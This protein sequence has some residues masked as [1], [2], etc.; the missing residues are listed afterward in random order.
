MKRLFEISS[1]EKQ[2]ILEMHESATKRN[3]LSEQIAVVQDSPPWKA[4]YPPKNIL[5]T[6]TPSGAIDFNN[7]IPKMKTNSQG[8]SG[9]YYWFYTTDEKGG[10]DVLP[11]LGLYK[12]RGDI[13]DL[14]LNFA[15]KYNPTAKQWSIQTQSVP[16]ANGVRFSNEFILNN[17]IFKNLE[18][19]SGGAVDGYRSG[20][21]SNKPIPIDKTSYELYV[22][23]FVNKN[24]A[25]G[26]SKAFKANLAP[27]DEFNQS[28]IDAIKKSGLYTALNTTTAPSTPPAPAR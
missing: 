15:L 24:P 6:I 8:I 25:S 13:G 17:V 18:G 27:N 1:E 10:N 7:I 23:N 19:A 14:H 9:D 16:G 20:M 3:Y 12:L 26:I 5:N 21:T 11:L 28:K 22:K 2:R 4:V